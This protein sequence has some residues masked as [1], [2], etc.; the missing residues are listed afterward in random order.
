MKRK[1]IWLD[2]EI[3][4]PAIATIR[5]RYGAE[6]DSAAIRLAIRILAESDHLNIELPAA[7]K[8]ARRSTSKP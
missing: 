3:D 1:L 6:N 7:P 8:H 4:Y 5:R 2:E